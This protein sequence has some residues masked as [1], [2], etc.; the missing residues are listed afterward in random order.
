V[1]D[2]R[3]A[4][5]LFDCPALVAV[6]VI[7]GKWKTRILWLLRERPYHF[8]DLRKTLPGVSAKVVDQQLAQLE[9]DGLV[10]RR[11]EMRGGLRFVYYSYSNYGRS[12]IPVLDD[13]GQ[14]GNEHG[15]RQ[16]SGR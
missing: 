1:S 14:W 13:L 8:G 12:L 9:S 15:S 11:E 3:Q 6:R 4:R 5:K 16:R 7:S 10:A 2:A